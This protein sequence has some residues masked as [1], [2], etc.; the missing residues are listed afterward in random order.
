MSRLTLV[1]KTALRPLSPA[2]HATRRALSG[3]PAVGHVDF[4]DFRRLRPVSSDFGGDRG[5]PID[6]YYV[7]SFLARHAADIRGHVLE[8]GDDTYTRR[9]GGER[10][11]R[12]DVLHVEA[13]NPKATIVADLADAPQ[14]PDAR[15]DAVILTQVLHLIYDYAAAL[16]TLRRILKP[17][18][19][20]LMTVPGITQT[21]AGTRWGDTW[22][23]S[24]TSLSV[25][26]LIVD[27][28][29]GDPA[30]VEVN[31]NA[32]VASAFLQGL[33]T[34]ELS[35]PELDYRDPSYPVIISARVVRGAGA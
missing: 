11:E 2:V 7:E 4:G 30:T 3:V 14:I 6:R 22:Y 20:L 27:H 1:L 15:F 12:R 8:I 34:S 29:P 17:G 33:A 28:F 31:G 35:V 26:R 10:V 23:W 5:R 24:F 9:F 21:A 32:L 18:G 16:R 19:I 25:S 13:G